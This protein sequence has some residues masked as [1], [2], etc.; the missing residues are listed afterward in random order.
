VYK[1][2]ERVA[3]GVSQP[4]MKIS[5]GKISYPGRKQVY[6]FESGS[7]LERDRICLAEE[8]APEGGTPLLEP[9]VVAGKL[10]RELPPIAETR[11]RA[12]QL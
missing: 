8:S 12:H 4:V 2:V 11:M 1:L 10:T 6:R 9:Y 3:D 5:P 7:M